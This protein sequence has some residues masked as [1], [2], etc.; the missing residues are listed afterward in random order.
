MAYSIKL[1]S[2][3]GP[4][5]LL[6]HLIEKAEVDIYDIP[7]AEITEQYLATIDT[8]QQLQLDVA[9]EFVVMAASLLSIKSKML[10]PKKEEQIYQQQL[11]D[12]DVEE[13]D[14]REELVQRLLEY[15]RYKML[16]EQL[17]EMEI[18]R[19][20][21]FTR[22]AENLAPYIKEEEHTV[23]DVTIYDLISALEKLVK[24]S[25]DKQ[26]PITKVSRDEVSIKDRMTE[27]RQ[28]VRV[29]GGMIRFSQL[30]SRRA[31][32][33]EIVTSFLALLELM[34]AK[35]ITCIQNQL[36][37]DIMICENTTKG[38]HTDGL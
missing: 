18:G 35:E 21:V 38:A 1:D 8:M 27:I 11:L 32:R 24:K 36:F 26:Q 17:R 7:I 23:K 28:L 10:L 14:P 3:E 31:T 25:K 5:D 20:R 13:N 16:A 4:L 2:F 19:N 6:L 30:F 9:S 34:K 29:G 33:A 15:K 37:Q 12:M 22:P